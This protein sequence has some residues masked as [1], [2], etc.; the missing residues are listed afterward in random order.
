M[1]IATDN[2]A[3]N[4]ADTSVKEIYILSNSS[5]TIQSIIKCPEEE[6]QIGLLPANDPT[7]TYFWAPSS[8]LSSSN[9]SNPFYGGN[10]T[11]QYQL[12][13][14][15]GSCTDT[16]FQNIF[17]PNLQLDAGL[18]TSYCNIPILLSA[19]FSSTVVSV[20]WSST[21]SFTDTLSNTSDLIIE[22]V[23]VFYVKVSD[24][25]CVQVD[26][27]QVLANRN[28]DHFH[29]QR[30]FWHCEIMKDLNQKKL[31]IFFHR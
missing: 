8:G 28:R 22:S 14:S 6:I 5:D 12:L 26:S 16:L 18:D 31:Q 30:V 10:S 9:V 13:I 4:V 23:A 11:Q 21:N 7:I 17:V 20:Q 29:F 24:G 19:T 1:L 25:N 2:N 27:V 15:N 3:C